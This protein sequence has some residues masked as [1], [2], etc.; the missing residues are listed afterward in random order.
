MRSYPIGLSLDALLLECLG[1]L[2]DPSWVVK[3]VIGGHAPDSSEDFIRVEEGVPQ[4]ESGVYDD[5]LHLINYKLE[6]FNSL[7]TA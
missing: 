3:Q 1:C 4:V 5:W 6:V 7:N 2:S